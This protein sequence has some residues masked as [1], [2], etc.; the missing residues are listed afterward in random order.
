MRVEPTSGRIIDVKGSP[1]YKMFAQTPQIVDFAFN[2]VKGAVFQAKSK[3]AEIDGRY[4][5]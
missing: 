3:V 5:C 2:L 4:H 1:P